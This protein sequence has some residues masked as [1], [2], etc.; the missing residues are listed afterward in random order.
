MTARSHM[1]R[2]RRARIQTAPTIGIWDPPTVSE[3]RRQLPHWVGEWRIYP[4]I[5]C[6][7]SPMSGLL[8][9]GIAHVHRYSD[10]AVFRHRLRLRPAWISA[11]LNEDSEAE[12]S[13]NDIH[14][15]WPGSG[16]GTGR[17]GG[18]RRF[19]AIRA[20]P[21]GRLYRPCPAAGSSSRRGLATPSTV[22]FAMVFAVQASDARTVPAELEIAGESRAGLSFGG[23]IGC[24]QCCEIM[25]GAEV[26]R[27]RRRCRDGRRHRA[28]FPMDGFV[29]CVRLR[30]VAAFR[31]PERSVIEMI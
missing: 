2:A 5:F 13:K 18:R 6:Y 14:R 11:R 7:N 20:R 17:G 26:S 29:S 25:T 19:H 27:R 23:K 16:V 3:C 22:P 12:R 8:S 28:S 15:A 21:P 10:T 30:P 4:G 9:P 1:P 24:G 31:P